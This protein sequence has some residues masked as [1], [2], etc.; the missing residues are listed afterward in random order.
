LAQD[1]QE[2]LQQVGALLYL[3]SELNPPDH[4]RGGKHWRLAGSCAL[5]APDKILTI[6]HILGERGAT[7]DYISGHYAVFF[8]YEGLFRIDSGTDWEDQTPGDN[9]AL[10]RLGNSLRFCS[11]LPYLKI[12]SSD[13]YSGKVS[14]CGYGS[15]RGLRTDSPNQGLQQRP[16]VSLGPPPRAVRQALSIEGWNHYDNIDLSW[17]SHDSGGLIAGAGNSGGPMLWRT[18]GVLSVVGISREVLSDQ[19]AGSWI[20]WDRL[21]WLQNKI[22]APAPGFTQ[23]LART[24]RLLKIQVD[25]GMLIPLEVPP[26]T[27]RVK[28]TLN[29]N[30]GMRLQMGIVPAPAPANLLS[31]LA[32]DDQASGQFLSREIESGPGAQEIT[33]GV[34]KVTR[35][36]LRQ[37]EVFTQLCVL[38]LA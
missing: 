19:Q 38:F 21:R 37:E 30:P 16:E 9:L 36:P 17:S 1:P 15:W 29:A 12:R 18:D 25:E 33:V 2:P 8:P 34:C 10:A 35:A 20:G 23:P 22:P 3:D 31:Q 28:I 7:P 11:P 14:V 4:E 13:K 26:G 5:L 24:W 27:T 6:G 32:M